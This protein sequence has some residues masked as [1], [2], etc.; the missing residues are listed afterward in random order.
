MARGRERDGGLSILDTAT[1]DRHRGRV[2]ADPTLALS[3]R[4]EMETS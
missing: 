1:R 3:C 4:T 2:P